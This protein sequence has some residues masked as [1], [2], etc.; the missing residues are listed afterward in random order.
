MKSIS[1]WSSLSLR[2][3]CTISM[4]VLERTHVNHSW[5]SSSTIMYTTAFCVERTWLGG[6]SGSGSGL[7]L[8]Q[9]MVTVRMKVR[10]GVGARVAFR[11]R[12]GVG[13]VGREVPRRSPAP[14]ARPAP[15]RARRCR[16]SRMRS[17]C[18]CCRRGASGRRC[19]PTQCTRRRTS[20]GAHA[21]CM[22]MQEEDHVCLCIR[23]KAAVGAAHV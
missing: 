19:T 15:E 6:G 20:T 5:P 12:V 14:S 11:A 21:V 7:G 18:C 3:S 13:G 2:W 16:A 1:E 22:Y 9:V 4:Y 10:V 23:G 8:G 17:C